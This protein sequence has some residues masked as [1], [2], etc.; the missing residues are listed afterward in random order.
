VRHQYEKL[1]AILA[2]DLNVEPMEES[3]ALYHRLMS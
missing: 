2:E 3:T 1:A